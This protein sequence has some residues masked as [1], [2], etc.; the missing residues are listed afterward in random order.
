L[1]SK[2]RAAGQ[3]IKRGPKVAQQKVGLRIKR[4]AFFDRCARKLNGSEGRSAGPQEQRSGG[5]AFAFTPVAPLRAELAGAF[6][7]NH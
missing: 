1:R 4:P 7:L 6:S 2:G 3:Q 5:C